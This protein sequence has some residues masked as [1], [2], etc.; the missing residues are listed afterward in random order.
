MSSDS[1]FETISIDRLREVAGGDGTPPSQDWVELHDV[2]NRRVLLFPPTS[3]RVNESP[4]DGECPPTRGAAK[5]MS[6]IRT[7]TGSQCVTETYD[8]IKAKLLGPDWKSR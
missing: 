5:A 4:S 1:G 8:H 7:Q 3:W 2:N 6:I